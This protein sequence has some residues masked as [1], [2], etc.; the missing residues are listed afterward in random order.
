M[1]DRVE[2]SIVKLTYFKMLTGKYYAE[3]E[4][5]VEGDPWD[6][7]DVVRGLMKARKLPGLCE[8]HGRFHVL[9][10]DARYEPRLLLSEDRARTCTCG[11]W[12]AEHPWGEECNLCACDEWS[13]AEADRVRDPFR[14][15]WEE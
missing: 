1:T 3:G 12:R 15:N 10:G 5:K 2:L 13:E 6:T 11:R 4:L 14:L 9:V 7:P 8:G